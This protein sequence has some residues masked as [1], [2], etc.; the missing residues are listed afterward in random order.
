MT[1]ADRQTQLG[2]IHNLV[3]DPDDEAGC[4]VYADWLEDRN[5]PLAELV[6]VQWEI[7][8]AERAGDSSEELVAHERRLLDG[9][10][11]DRPGRSGEASDD[12]E[13]GK[14]WNHG[15]HGGLATLILHQSPPAAPA[16][17]P[18]RFGWYSIRYKCPGEFVHEFALDQ[19]G[20]RALLAS[21]VMAG[22]VGLELSS[23]SLTSA[24]VR[25]LAK[26]PAVAHLLR[27]DLRNNKLDAAAVEA[28]AASPHLKGLL[29]LE[30]SQN[31][32]GDE[33]LLAL[34]SSERGFPRLRRLRLSSVKA[35]AKGIAALSRSR[36][37]ELRSL[38]LSYNRLDLRAARA[39]VHSS[40]FPE[41]TGLNLGS[42]NLDDRRAHALA[43]AS[44]LPKLT[45]LDLIDNKK[46][47]ADGAVALIR[48]P[49]LAGLR[50][51]DLSGCPV[52]TPTVE[53][54]CAMGRLFRDGQLRLRECGLTD[55][56]LG[57]LAAAPATAVLRTLDLGN[58]DAI[59]D[60]GAQALAASAHLK[61][62]R[63]LSLDFCQIGPEGG[64][65][66][67]A[68][69]AF[70]QL[71][72]LSLEDNPVGDEGLV[73]LARWHRARGVRELTLDNAGISTAGVLAVV[74]SGDLRGLWLL[75]LGG[76]EEIGDEGIAA[77]ANCPD[78]AD[79][80]DLDVYAVGLTDEGAD[81]LIASPYLSAG[82]EVCL[83]DQE[84]S[85]EITARLQARFAK[86]WV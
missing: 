14:D 50:G 80:R 55:E 70:P 18:E 59:T 36:F 60:A 25:L 30:L 5:D 51:L 12:D 17:W 9:L 66:L 42:T 40:S 52:G 28:L 75:G 84:F 16:G 85:D 83:F 53:A 86:V 49:N 11:F 79:L 57:V 54:L 35:T 21:P 20:L 27:L 3:S 77:L 39:L 31:D 43:E 29:E 19:Q 6:R 62:L 4:L 1:V 78:V 34:A 7:R 37:P 15:V 74:R 33:G 38:D 13:P 56:S 45:S 67:A 23:L 71:R 41:L 73:A 69:E 72:D 76:N 47:T 8:R 46:L 2:L 32:I 26:S 61:G 82:L 81:A 65:A 44:G 24:S 48:S 10:R 68:L 58:N 22:C 63:S 64:R